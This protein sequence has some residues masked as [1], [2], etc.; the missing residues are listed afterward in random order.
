MSTPLKTVAVKRRLCG[1]VPLSMPNRPRLLLPGLARNSCPSL[2][3]RTVW[4]PG[5]L[6]CLA[7]E[8]AM[9]RRVP[10]TR[11]ATGGV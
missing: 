11:C 2:R 8:H 1:R 6:R 3:P 10:P 9:L 5:S 4:L 7:G